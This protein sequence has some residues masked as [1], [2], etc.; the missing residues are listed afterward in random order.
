M[1]NMWSGETKDEKAD[2][3]VDVTGKNNQ[4][5]QGAMDDDHIGSLETEKKL[6]E[7]RFS[8]VLVKS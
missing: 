3:P 5:G 7:G 8:Q 6:D 4:K 2:M 1:G